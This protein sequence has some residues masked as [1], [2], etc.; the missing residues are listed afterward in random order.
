MDLGVVLAN[1]VN[2]VQSQFPLAGIF[3]PNKAHKKSIL[4]PPGIRV[5]NIVARRK[6]LF[7]E[8]DKPLTNNFVSRLQVC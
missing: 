3:L 6:M 8:L 7:H 2:A 4:L 1:I 5:F